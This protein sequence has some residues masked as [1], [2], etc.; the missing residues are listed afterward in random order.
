M[1]L[2]PLETVNFAE[3]AGKYVIPQGIISQNTAVSEK[4]FLFEFI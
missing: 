1:K 3:M 4:P 2:R